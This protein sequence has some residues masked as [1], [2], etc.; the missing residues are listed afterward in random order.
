MNDNDVVTAYIDAAAEPARARL[1]ALR[2]VILAEA[3]DAVERIA[4]GL[5]TWQQAEN[6]IH[7]GAFQNHIGVYPGAAAVVVFAA[8]LTTFKTSKGAIQIP[9]DAPLPLELVRR[10][11]RWRFEESMKKGAAT[12]PTKKQ[13]TM[14]KTATKPTK[15]A[16]TTKAATTKP[17]TKNAATAKPETKNAATKN[18]ATTKAATTKPKTTKP[19]TT[20]AATKNTATTKNTAATKAATTTT[21]PV[22]PDIAAYNAARS[23]TDRAVCDALVAHI[24]TALPDAQGKVWHGHPVWFLQG[25]PVVGYSTHKDGTRLL[26]WSGQSFDEPALAPLGKFKA[27]EAR[28]PRVDDVDER[29]LRRW[30]GKARAIQWDYKNIAKNKGVLA[31][32]C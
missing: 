28:C 5:A 4:Y 17:E 15:K 14:K 25:N 18:T 21:P 24:A 26:L 12:K 3:P 2:K 22:P 16:A 1:R 11:T 23:S 13:A 9:H 31:R 8:E 30:L 19:K 29:A 27:A 32:L 10:I 6:L 7:L 20:K